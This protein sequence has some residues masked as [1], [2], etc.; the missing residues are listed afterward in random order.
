MTPPLLCSQALDTA[1]LPSAQA[2][3]TR[4]C[5]APFT[6]VC[7]AM[8]SCQNV[9]GTIHAHF[10]CASPAGTFAK[11]SSSSS[12][13][14]LRYAHRYSAFVENPLFSSLKSHF[15]WVADI[16]HSR[17]RRPLLRPAHHNSIT[18]NTDLS[19]RFQ[20]FFTYLTS[21]GATMMAFLIKHRLLSPPPLPCI[22]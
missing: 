17:E 13:S 3:L 1:F 12:F 4:P 2:C 22:G 9:E 6:S 11:D 15:S 16:A 8:R 14:M 18:T 5:D 19:K 20:F 10:T 21:R 7:L